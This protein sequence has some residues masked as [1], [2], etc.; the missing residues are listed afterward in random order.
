MVRRFYGRFRTVDEI[1]VDVA[2]E[3]MPFVVRGRGEIF[4]AW[5]DDSA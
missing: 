2:R 3:K 5:D 4:A 1:L